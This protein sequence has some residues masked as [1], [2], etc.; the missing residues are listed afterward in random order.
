MNRPLF[1]GMILVGLAPPV[2]PE[3]VP[4]G[5]PI[6]LEA[7]ESGSNCAWSSATAWTAQT[8]AGGVGIGDATVGALSQFEGSC[9]GPGGLEKIYRFQAA[10]QG[11]LTVSVAPQTGFDVAF[12]VRSDCTALSEIECKDDF[13]ESTAETA[14]LPVDSGQDYFIFVDGSSSTE[15]GSYT[16]LLTPPTAAGS[17]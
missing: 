17:P 1:F 14:S 11:I 12:Y 6:F 8:I 10:S 4:A 13:F 15:S 7:F 3:S 5:E 2:F 9:I 16:L